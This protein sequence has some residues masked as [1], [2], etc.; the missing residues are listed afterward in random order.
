LLGQIHPAGIFMAAG[1]AAWAGLWEWA[2]IRWRYWLIGSALGSITLLPWLVYAL[3]ETA[4]G[5][6]SNRSIV[7]VL[8]LTYFFRWLVEPLGIRERAYLGADFVDLLRYPLVWGRPTYLLG[9]AH[10]LLAALAL[11]ALVRGALWLWCE[12]SRWASL[13]RGTESASAFTVGAALWGFGIAFTLTLL[14]IRHYYMVLAFPLMFVWC[15]RWVL[16]SEKTGF[17]RRLSGRTL[18]GSLCAIQLA[19]AVG[20]L[21]YIHVNRDRPLGGEYGIPYS[22]QAHASSPMSGTRMPP[23]P[24]TE[25]EP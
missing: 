5:E 16:A 14:P 12:R 4:A 24:D 9:L 10:A 23:G 3:G 15:A 8:K 13:W 6:V 18:L 19:V 21:G 22:V 1:F 20:H 2:H 7:N 11:T 25:T 17:L